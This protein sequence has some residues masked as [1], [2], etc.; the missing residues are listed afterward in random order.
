LC[1]SF[2]RVIDGKP[3]QEQIHV[4]LTNYAPEVAAILNL[5]GGLHIEQRR[6]LLDGQTWAVVEHTD[7]GTESIIPPSPLGSVI[8]AIKYIEDSQ[9]SKFYIGYS[10]TEIPELV[11]PFSNQPIL[12]NLGPSDFAFW[13]ID[14]GLVVPRVRLD[15]KPG[16][17]PN[18]FNLKSRGVLLAAILGTEDLDVHNINPSTV[19]LTREEYPGVSPLRWNYE[20]VATPFYGPASECHDLNGDGYLDLTLKFDVQELIETLELDEEAGNTI[21]LWLNGNLVQELGGTPIRGRDSIK[22]K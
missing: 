18:P 13:S 11:V 14:T 5:P 4:S 21:T 2:E 3:Y 6:M 10:M 1:F 16:S 12:S 17:C 15:I 7:F 9:N 19:F 22:I 20:D 8:L